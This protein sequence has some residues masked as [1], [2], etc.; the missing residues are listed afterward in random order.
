LSTNPIKDGFATAVANIAFLGDTDV[1]PLPFENHVFHDRPDA[2]CALLER[3]HVD[4]DGFMQR[5]PP[6]NESTLS[7]AGYTGFRWV[8]QIDAIWNAYLLGL[9]ISIGDRIEAARI[10]RAKSHIFSYRFAPDAATHRLFDDGAWAA[11]QQQ[12]LKYAEAASHVLI[13]DI[14]DFYPRVYHHRLEN[15][16]D[17]LK[18][19][20]HI[21]NRIIALLKNFSGTSYGLP[22]GGPA[23][24]LLSELLLNRTDRLLMAEGLQ[25]CR[26]AD[27]YHIFANSV[28]DAYRGLTALSENLYRD[29]G[30]ALQKSKTRLLT[31]KDFKSSSVFDDEEDGEARSFLALSLR[32]DPYSP[33]AK[34]DYDELKS[35]IQT[36]DVVAMLGRELRKSR[37]HAALTRKLVKSIGYL[38]PDP[39]NALVLT[40][41]DNIEVLAPV[42]TT[43][44]MVI[45]EV[46]DT[47]EESVQARACERI[48]S[49]IIESH[50]LLQIDL[51]VAFALRVLRKRRSDESEALLA[52]TISAMSRIL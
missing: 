1:F 6:N 27:D 33:T 3:I 51:N 9:V 8:T 34:E 18:V 16:L 31:T 29:E 24:R 2:A 10:D 17:Q 49:L 37:V 26:F 12:S 15:A 14:A 4:F 48:R 28:A 43:V 32:Y 47:L 44:M 52:Q 42:F 35:Q 41:L 19:D 20:G 5:Q 25:F 13:C 45:R 23:A 38:D 46:C 36:F 11:F 30:L 50:Y 22:I 7:L 21:P 39:R 40:L